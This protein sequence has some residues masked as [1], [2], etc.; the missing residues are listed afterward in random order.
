MGSEPARVAE[1]LDVERISPEQETGEY[2]TGLRTPSPRDDSAS[3]TMCLVSSLPRPCPAHREGTR[4]RKENGALRA[5]LTLHQIGGG[6]RGP[7]HSGPHRS[8]ANRCVTE[9]GVPRQLTS[10]HASSDSID[11]Q[12]SCLGCHLPF[13]GPVQEGSGRLSPRGQR[14]RAHRLT[15][16]TRTATEGVPGQVCRC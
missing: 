13:E 7:R 11:V 6:C 1:V 5:S 15:D 4:A 10:L 9:P 16:P 2:P 12:A 14:R 8:A 3:R